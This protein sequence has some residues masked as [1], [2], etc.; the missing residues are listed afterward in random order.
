MLRRV[1][2]GRI[3]DNRLRAG[4]GQARLYLSRVVENRSEVQCGTIFHNLKLNL[5]ILVIFQH[6]LACYRGSG[7]KCKSMSQ[8]GLGQ[9]RLNLSRVV[10]K[11]SG[12]RCIIIIKKLC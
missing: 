3:C 10:E 8:V 12:I 1:G 5:V 2:P 11:R 4:L 7:H 9:I 6:I